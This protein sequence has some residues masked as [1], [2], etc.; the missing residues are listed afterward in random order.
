MVDMDFGT[1]AVKITPA[2]DPNDFEVA[3]RHNLALDN[4]VI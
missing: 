3:K 4:I 2:H 1:G